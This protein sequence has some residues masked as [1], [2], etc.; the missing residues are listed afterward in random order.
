MSRKANAIDGGSA[1][2]E[3]SSVTSATPA[4]LVWRPLALIFVAA[5]LLRAIVLLELSQAP[6]FSAL[7]GDSMGYHLWATEIAAGDWVGSEVFY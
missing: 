1:Q 2:H 3:D 5:L 4:T 7:I 6:F